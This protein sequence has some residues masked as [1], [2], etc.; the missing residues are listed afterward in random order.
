MGEQKKLNLENIT[1]FYAANA[2]VK[3]GKWKNVFFE[4]KKANSNIISIGCLC[5]ILNNAFRNVL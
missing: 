3:F 1:N 2:K 5:H 4:L